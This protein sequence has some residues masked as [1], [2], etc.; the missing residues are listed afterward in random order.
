MR[1]GTCLSKRPYYSDQDR[2]AGNLQGQRCRGCCQ[3]S[4]GSV[5]RSTIESKP[6]LNLT[7]I[8]SIWTYHLSR[9]L[10][11]PETSPSTSNRH[12][13]PT[14]RPRP[15]EALPLPY[16]FSRDPSFLLLPS[17]QEKMHRTTHVHRSACLLAPS[18]LPLI[19]A[20]FVSRQSLTYLSNASASEAA[21]FV[22]S[23]P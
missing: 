18:G 21:T 13:R 4:N 3:S 19:L 22:H 23:Q 9:V 15:A 11:P 16:F 10:V 14:V 6:N 7:A 2:L 5:N 20:F 17:G 12:T 8:L 1:E